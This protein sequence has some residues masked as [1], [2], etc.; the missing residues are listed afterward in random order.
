MP[1]GLP[2]RVELRGKLIV[3][4]QVF[5]KGDQADVKKHLENGS[6]AVVIRGRS[7]V[8]RRSEYNIVSR[9]TNSQKEARENGFNQTP[10]DNSKRTVRAS[11]R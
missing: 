8:L 1:K 5:W 10:S 11:R 3:G 7:L 6:V 4:E 9:E 2:T